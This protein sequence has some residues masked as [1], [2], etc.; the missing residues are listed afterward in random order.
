MLFDSE[1]SLANQEFSDQR[2]AHNMM[3]LMEMM[4]MFMIRDE[5]AWK[6]INVEET[7]S[8]KVSKIKNKMVNRFNGWKE[9]V[10]EI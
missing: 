6:V 7:S 9:N 5:E 3:C 8:K 10:N 2:N 1:E 4:E